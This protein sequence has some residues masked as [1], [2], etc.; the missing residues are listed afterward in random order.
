MDDH[1]IIVENKPISSE[2][3]NKMVLS[4]ADTIDAMMELLSPQQQMFVEHFQG[5]NI[6]EALEAAGYNPTS[7]NSTR[8]LNNPVIKDI[9]KTLRETANKVFIADLREC[10]YHLTSIA[11]DYQ[12]STP[13]RLAALKL[14]MQSHGALTPAVH[15]QQHDNRSVTFNFASAAPKLLNALEQMDHSDELPPPTTL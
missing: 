11:R 9:I 3:L 12:E 14:L 13:N 8:L 4:V 5:Y 15:L 2:P 7:A 10:Q 6:N 1:N